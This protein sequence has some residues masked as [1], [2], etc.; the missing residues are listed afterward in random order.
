[1]QCA[2]LINEIKQLLI[3]LYILSVVL[4]T[5]DTCRNDYWHSRVLFPATS[6]CTWCCV[7]F[8][9]R[10]SVH[11]RTS[12]CFLDLSNESKLIPIIPFVRHLTSIL[13]PQ[14]KR[15][16][17]PPTFLLSNCWPCCYLSFLSPHFPPFAPSLNALCESG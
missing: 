12:R 17:V 11:Y 6:F 15:M 7:I 4:L 3:R 13:L 2:T 9:A 16:N 8:W 5:C 14:W 10:R 1:M